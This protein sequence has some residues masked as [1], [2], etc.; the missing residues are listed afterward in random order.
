MDKSDNHILSAIE[1][2]ND[3]NSAEHSPLISADYD[4]LMEESGLVSQIQDS[5]SKNV[6]TESVITETKTSNVDVDEHIVS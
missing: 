2:S 6:K 1:K 3:E 5:S 4:Q